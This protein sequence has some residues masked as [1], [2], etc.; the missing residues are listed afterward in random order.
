MNRYIYIYTTIHTSKLKHSSPVPEPRYKYSSPFI[1]DLYL[2]NEHRSKYFN[3]RR[4]LR[5][6]L[7]LIFRFTTRT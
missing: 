1:G 4:V 7:V 3:F 2:N 5:E 6:I